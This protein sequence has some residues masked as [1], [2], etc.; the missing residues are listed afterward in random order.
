MLLEIPFARMGAVASAAMLAP[1]VFAAFDG[2]PSVST[3]LAL[4]GLALGLGSVWLLAGIFTPDSPVEPEARGY[5]LRSVAGVG[6]FGL[7]LAFEAGAHAFAPASLPVRVGGA[8][9]ALLL[10]HLVVRS[11]A[12]TRTALGGRPA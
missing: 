8:A 5:V 12:R 11:V 2:K 6:F 10:A 1:G 7:V 9:G 4:A 3:G